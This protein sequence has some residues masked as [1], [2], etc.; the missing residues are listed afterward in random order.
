MEQHRVCVACGNPLP[1]NKSSRKYCDTCAAKVNKARNKNASR[2]RSDCTTIDCLFCGCSILITSKSMLCHAC[3]ILRDSR[4]A[5]NDSI[6]ASKKEPSIP[7]PTEEEIRKNRD[8]LL[9][10]HNVNKPVIPK[11]FTSGSYSQ[12]PK[13]KKYFKRPVEPETA[14]ISFRNKLHP[15]TGETLIVECRGSGFYF[16]KR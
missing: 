6:D 11:I 10:R 1:I 7:L 12:T 9:S 14:P 8:K 16:G 5:H 3:E 4:E 2:L 13:S 15:E